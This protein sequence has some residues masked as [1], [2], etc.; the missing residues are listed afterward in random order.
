MNEVERSPFHVDLMYQDG[1]INFLIYIY[2]KC[3]QSVSSDHPPAPLLQQVWR[4][5]VVSGS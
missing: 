5:R 4:L 3:E 1:G 2:M